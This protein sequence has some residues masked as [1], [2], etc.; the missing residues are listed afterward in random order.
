[1]IYTYTHTFIVI[2]H[3]MP[4]IEM[5]ITERRHILSDKPDISFAVCYWKF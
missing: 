2:L 3:K 4:Y 5:L 1:M